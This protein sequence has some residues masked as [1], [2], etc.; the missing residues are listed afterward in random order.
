MMK[1]HFEHVLRIF[2]LLTVALLASATVS[3][4]NDEQQGRHIFRFDTFGDEAFWGD[5]IKLHQAIE[6]TGFGGVG[7]PSAR[8]V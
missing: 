3:A 2:T 4:G 6:G 8:F 7:G 5:T 1:H